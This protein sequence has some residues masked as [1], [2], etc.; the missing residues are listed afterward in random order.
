[1]IKRWV[2]T[3]EQP[4]DDAG[5]PSGPHWGTS[6][7]Q[8][9]EQGRDDAV[10]HG[11]VGEPNKESRGTLTLE[12]QQWF[13]NGDQ[14]STGD[15]DYYLT[16]YTVPSP[17]QMDGETRSDTES[18]SEDDRSQTEADGLS[19]D[20]HGIILE[21]PSDTQQCP[22]CSVVFNTMRILQEHLGE[23]H[24]IR[25]VLFRCRLCKTIFDRVHRLECHAPRCKKGKRTPSDAGLKFECDGC[26]CRFL[27]KSGNSQH[28]R[29]RHPEIANNRRIKAIKLEAKQKRE[30]RHAAKR[31]EK[32]A[33]EREQE[34]LLAAKEWARMQANREREAILVVEKPEK[35]NEAWVLRTEWDEAAIEILLDIYCEMGDE[36]GLHTRVRAALQVA[37]YDISLKR[38][39]ERK[40]TKGFRFSLL[41]KQEQNSK[42]EGVAPDQTGEAARSTPKAYPSGQKTAHKGE[43][44]DTSTAET[45]LLSLEKA[46]EAR[47]LQTKWDA[48][49]IKILLDYYCKT[50]DTKGLHT[51]VRAALRVAGYDISQKRISEKKRTKG[52]QTALLNRQK[53]NGTEEEVAP[54][55]TGEAARSTPKAYP[56]GQKTAYVMEC[57]DS[58]TVETLLLSLETSGDEPEARIAALYR[59]VQK[60]GTEGEAAEVAYAAHEQLLN[61]FIAPGP[62]APTKGAKMPRYR[63]E[64]KVRKIRTKTLKGKAKERVERY[65][66]LQQKWKRNKKNAVKQVLDGASDAKCQIDAK[67]IKATYTDRFE[68]V[69]PRVDLSNYPGPFSEPVLPKITTETDSDH[70]EQSGQ[71]RQS[72]PCPERLLEAV[73]ASEVRKA[74]RAMRTGSA[75]GPDRIT[76]AQLKKKTEENPGFLAGVYT[77]WMMTSKV[78]EKL[79]ASRSLLLPKG[80]TDLQNIGNW[81]PLSISSVIMRLYTKILAKRLTKAVSLHPSQRGFIPAPGVEQNSFFWSTWYESRRRKRELLRWLSWIWRKPSTP[82]RTICSRKDFKDWEFPPSSSE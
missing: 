24:G 6:N 60:T 32:Q 55:Q 73:S 18:D 36:K 81:R 56:S 23:T 39:S 1:M 63:K 33:A 30:K 76:V 13:R 5:D 68:S 20:E 26:A 19:G 61:D 22:K 17:S 9:A 16:E 50:R 4:L 10:C 40:R 43:C 7:R 75:A 58:S 78:P 52:F 65:R 70:E 29:H 69:G 35:A 67:V 59:T 27:T 44:M 45:L 37:G 25:D 48:A 51:R 11:P 41:D 64:T 79:K 3:R 21:L 8:T 42:E 53:Q 14:I 62:M 46:N 72:E 28:E 71:N 80:T 2:G 15:L 49:A 74:V 31:L 12:G 54:E 77:L 34:E 66:N 82:Y 38:I 57:L 47:V